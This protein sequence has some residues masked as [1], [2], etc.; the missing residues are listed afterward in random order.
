MG[1][2]WNM[3][4]DAFHQSRV[5]DISDIFNK[6]AIV[7]YILVFFGDFTF[8]VLNESPAKYA[9]RPDSSIW[10][11]KWYVFIWRMLKLKLLSFPQDKIVK[12]LVI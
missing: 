6:N 11:E 12:S 9:L 2:A 1:L 10:F 5:K 7:S 8:P 3:G 4:K